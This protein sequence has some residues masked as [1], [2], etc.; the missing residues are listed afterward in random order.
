MTLSR[1]IIDRCPRINIGYADDTVLI[2]DT[3]RK[4]YSPLDSVVEKRTINLQKT[5]CLIIG[6]RKISKCELECGEL[7]KTVTEVLIS[8]YF[9]RR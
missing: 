2:T 1:F 9:N 5:E 7:F 6:K 3:G 8:G 4:L